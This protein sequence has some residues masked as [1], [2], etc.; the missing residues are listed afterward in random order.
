LACFLERSNTKTAVI[1]ASNDDVS[2]NDE[3]PGSDMRFEVIW[4]PVKEA[5]AW[6]YRGVDRS[7]LFR[8]FLSGQ[9]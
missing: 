3:P 7:E 8:F 2:F 1:R 6:K 5:F 9:R 4:D